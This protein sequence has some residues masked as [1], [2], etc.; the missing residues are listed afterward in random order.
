[1]SSFAHNGANGRLITSSHD[2]ADEQARQQ[3]PHQFAV[4]DEEQRA[5][6]HPVLLERR[7]HDRGGGRGGQAGR[8][9]RRRADRAV[10]ERTDAPAERR[11]VIT[12]DFGQRIQMSHEQLR[13]L[14]ADVKNGVLDTVVY[15][16]SA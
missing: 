16:V 11:I 6:L 8:E 1:M 4:A 9:Q 7:Q 15:G 13:D 10:P 3:R 2:H 5:R 14:V 12:D